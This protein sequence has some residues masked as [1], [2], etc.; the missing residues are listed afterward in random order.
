[1]FDGSDP[2]VAAD[3][4][5]MATWGL[6]APELPGWETVARG[7]RAPGC[8]FHFR[9]AT[10]A[11]ASRE[12]RFEYGRE[13]RKAPKGWRPL[14]YNVPV[15]V[16]RPTADGGTETLPERLGIRAVCLTPRSELGGGRGHRARGG[17]PGGDGRPRRGRRSWPA[18][19]TSRSLAGKRATPVLAALRWARERLAPRP[20]SAAQ[21]DCSVQQAAAGECAIESDELVATGTPSPI[22][23]SCPAGFDYEGTTN[24]CVLTFNPGGGIDPGG[25]NS[26]N[27]GNGNQG[28]G[29]NTGPRTVDFELSCSGPT[30]GEHGSCSV[31]A[32]GENLGSLNY[33]WSAAINN[34]TV[35]TASG[36]SS[37]GGTAT[38]GVT[39]RVEITDPAGGIAAATLTADVSVGA[40][41][42]GLPQSSA[43]PSYED[44]GLD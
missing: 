44:L 31:S 4:R 2:E 17:D 25:T 42:W 18:R 22:P 13:A 23:I 3:L 5:D 8:V 16:T 14:V 28:G 6:G 26:G 35:A 43:E 20:L 12:Y 21:E 36:Q 1:M 7:R 33:S 11:Y 19:R 9:R 37:W 39:V 32:P 40:R 38:E 34:A 10:G 24:S 27:S 29:E 41:S 30:R 15:V